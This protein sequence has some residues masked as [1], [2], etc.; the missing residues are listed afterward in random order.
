LVRSPCSVLIVDDEKIIRDG[1]LCF[2]WDALGFA[3][4]E[5]ASDG[6]EALEVLTRAPVDLLISD[7]RMPLMDGLAL[8]K[9]VRDRWPRTKAVILTGFRDFEFVKEALQARVLEYL[10][11]PVDPSELEAVVRRLKAEIDEEDRMLLAPGRTPAMF[12]VIR[13]PPGLAADQMTRCRTDLAATL[14]TGLIGQ[15]HSGAD[16]VLFLDRGVTSDQTVSALKCFFQD[17]LVTLYVGWGATYQAALAALDPCFYHSGDPGLV[18]WSQAPGPLF[19]APEQETEL[20]QTTLAGKND[21][22]VAAL[23]SLRMA[24]R[25]DLQPSTRELKERV[26][27]LVGQVRR[28][29]E[30]SSLAVPR[31]GGVEVET[32]LGQT[33]GFSLFWERAGEFFLRASEEI[34]EANSGSRS[35]SRW[36]VMRAVRH[37]EENLAQPLTLAELAELG[38]LNPSYFSI[39]FKK[40]MG[41]NYVDFI[42]R[43]RI[44][45]ASALLHETD[46]KVYEVGLAVGYTDTKHFTEVFKEIS[47]I[48]PLAFRRKIV[49][50]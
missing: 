25:L 45:K 18:L 23:D 11:K 22:V 17:P 41:M 10:L 49:V 38:R 34:F 6:I 39:Q 1:L 29:L 36:A 2:P 9:E 30:R 13:I 28:V 44:T 21:Q 7:V 27:V 16:L 37:I 15:T 46:L 26:A 14:G 4:V 3:R 19:F 47:G 42:K 8:C 20:V 12:A 31:L 5:S 43:A 32:S 24:W 33:P 48:T 40:E 35:S 50:P